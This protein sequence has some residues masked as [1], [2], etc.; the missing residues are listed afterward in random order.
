M[1][2]ITSELS[3]LLVETLTRT[4]LKRLCELTKCQKDFRMRFRQFACC[5][6]PC[7]AVFEIAL[8]SCRQSLL[9]PGLVGWVAAC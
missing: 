9:G 8:Q 6:I 7:L 4:P 5:F 1:L 3:D 2:A